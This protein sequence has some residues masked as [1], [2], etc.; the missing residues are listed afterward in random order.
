MAGVGDR[1]PGTGGSTERCCRWRTLSGDSL[2]KIYQDGLGRVLQ[3]T[4]GRGDILAVEGNFVGTVI[5]LMNRGSAMRA[6]DL[7][8]PTVG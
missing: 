2:R 6:G 4:R 1:R 3:R 7:Q 5:L 8:P